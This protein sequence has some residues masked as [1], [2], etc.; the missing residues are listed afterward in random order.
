MVDKSPQSDA[1]PDQFRALTETA[2]WLQ[3]RNRRWTDVVASGDFSQRLPVTIAAPE[4]L[5]PLVRGELGRAAHLHAPC[6]GALAAFAG[7]GA[8]GTPIRRNRHRL[9][10]RATMAPVRPAP[11]CRRFPAMS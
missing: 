10:G 1:L 3:P 8:D 6:L 2:S 9:R 7:A 5:T 11:P 4:R